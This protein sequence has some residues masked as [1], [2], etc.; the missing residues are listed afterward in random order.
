MSHTHSGQALMWIEKELNNMGVNEYR[1]CT[2]NDSYVC[3]CYGNF[4]SVCHRQLSKSGNL[5]EKYR[6]KKLKGSIDKYGYVT[7]RITVDG[8]KRHLKAHRLML[9]AWLGEHVNLV[10]NHK[11]GNKKNNSLDNLEWC[12][13]AENNKHAIETGL[14]DFSK[15]KRKYKIPL[16]DWI[17]IY[18]LYKHCGVSLSELGRKNGVSHDTI[19]KIIEKVSLILPQEVVN[20]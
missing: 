17:I 19:A 10:V 8:K 5:I 11:D 16:Y 13:V 15:I 3:D 6:I 2:E 9:N 14:L 20:V 12:T 1:F 18:V 7:Y 4:Y